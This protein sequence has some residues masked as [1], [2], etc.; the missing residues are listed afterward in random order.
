MN[1]RQN[2]DRHA[3]DWRTLTMSRLSQAT[4]LRLRAHG[5]RYNNTRYNIAGDNALSR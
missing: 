4:P 3:H 1:H 2:A 5:T